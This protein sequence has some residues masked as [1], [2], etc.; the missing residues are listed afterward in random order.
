[1]ETKNKQA[2]GQT[3]IEKKKNSKTDVWVY[4]FTAFTLLVYLGVYVEGGSSREEFIFKMCCIPIYFFYT[5]AVHRVLYNRMNSYISSLIGY[6]FALL[7]SQMTTKLLLIELLSAIGSL[8][9]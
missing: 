4:L 9:E 8:F 2:P 3:V 5:F 1:M 6:V 7:F